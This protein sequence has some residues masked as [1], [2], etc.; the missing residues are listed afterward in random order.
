M[1]W[2]V[3]CA[4]LCAASAS[5]QTPRPDPLT[6]AASLGP[7][8]SGSVH[9][10]VSVTGQQQRLVGTVRLSSSGL[11]RVVADGFLGLAEDSATEWSAVVGYAVPVAGR[12]QLVGATGLSAV[13][14]HRYESGGCFDAFLFCIPGDAIRETQPARLGWPVEVG[15]SGPVSGAFGMG[16]RAFVTVNGEQTYGGG[17]VELRLSPVRPRP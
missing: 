7:T 8:K 10:G 2:L 11:G 17:A 14:V 3:L 12:W 9:A 1:R 13:R 6:L 4:A 16:A 15:V 5:A